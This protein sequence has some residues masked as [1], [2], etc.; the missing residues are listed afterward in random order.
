[1][2]SDTEEMDSE[3]ILRIR[4]FGSPEIRVCGSPLPPLHSRRGLW[5]LAILALR[6]GRPIDRLQLAGLLWPDSL[7][8]TALHNLRQTLADLRRALSP[9]A[10]C[11]QAES[12]SLLALDVSTAHIDALAFDAAVAEGTEIGRAS[13]RE[14]V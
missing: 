11:L 4:L 6:A 2:V 14:R 13:C 7:D 8:S 10:I 1:M 5:L 3:P 9:A 12:K